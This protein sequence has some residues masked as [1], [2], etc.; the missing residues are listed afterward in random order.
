M[1][2]AILADL[3]VRGS[4]LDVFEAQMSAAIRAM[5]ERDVFTAFVAGDTFDR[6][7]IHDRSASTGRITWTVAR[8]LANSGIRWYLVDGNHDKPNDTTRSAN[9]SLASLDNVTVISEPSRIPM[10]EGIE[11]YCVPWYYEAQMAPRIEEALRLQDEHVRAETRVLIGHGQV[12]GAHMSGT[13]YCEHGHFAIG[14]NELLA[15]GFDHIALGDFHRRQPFYV[16]ALRQL[17]HGEEGNPQGFEIYDTDSN[18]VEWVELREAPQYRTLIWTQG[19]PKPVTNPA[20]VT[21]I[22]TE[23]W[24]PTAAEIGDIG[25]RDK[26]DPV[27][28]RQAIQR[29]ID[30][31]PEGI[32]SDMHAV[33]DLYLKANDIEITKELHDELARLLEMGALSASGLQRSARGGTLDIIETHIKEI[34][35]H[36]DLSIDWSEFGSLVAILA[37]NGT[38]KTILA[39]ADFACLHGEFPSYPGPL[40]DVMTQNGS[41]TSELRTVFK[42]GEDRYVASRRLHQTAKTKSHEAT[43][44][45]MEAGAPRIVAGPKVGDFDKAIEHLLGSKQSAL[46]SWFS[47]QGGT[48]DICL[49]PVVDRRRVFGELMG[50]DGLEELSQRSK[51]E[52]AKETAELGEIERSIEAEAGLP[53]EIRAKDEE[54]IRV[55][56]QLLELGKEQTGADTV[57]KNLTDTLVGRKEILARGEEAHKGA[58]DIPRLRTD[59]QLARLDSDAAAQAAASLPSFEAKASRLEYADGQLSA[60]QKYSSWKTIDDNLTTSIA[61]QEN[62]IALYDITDADRGNA[63]AQPTVKVQLDQLNTEAGQLVEKNAELNAA[64]ASAADQVKAL[65]ESRQLSPL[66]GTDCAPCPILASLKAQVGSTEEWKARGRDA[67]LGLES[68]KKGLARLGPL[69]EAEENRLELCK[70]ASLKIA[71]AAVHLAPARE[72]LK[73]YEDQ[74]QSHRKLPPTPS[75]L[76]ELQAANLTTTAKVLR[77]EVEQ[78]PVLRDR[79]SKKEELEARTTERH[80][81]LAAAEQQ[82]KLLPDL[83]VL[84]S[85]IT[86]A[87]LEATEAVLRKDSIDGQVV[88]AKEHR[89][90]TA[91]ALEALNVRRKTVWEN[92]QRTSAK[93]ARVALLRVLQEAFGKKGAQALLLDASMADLEQ[94]AHEIVSEATDGRFA[95]EIKTQTQNADGSMKEDLAIM[96]IDQH[97]R[98]DVSRFSGGEKRL[99]QIALRIAM[100]R[101]IARLTGRSAGAIRIDETF[102]ALDT[103]RAIVVIEMFE[104]LKDRFSRVILVTHNPSFASRIPDRIELGK[105]TPAPAQAEPEEME[106]EEAPL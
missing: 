35:P 52:A 80:R 87:A 79:A 43:L 38:G 92:T 91:E 47:G 32:L 68:N 49:L 103:E 95:I 31:I 6:D 5:V 44:E 12:R 59:Y 40:Y 96:A 73:G 39:E 25:P 81:V 2:I 42:Y 26:I 71:S 21:R 36:L 28:E 8:L 10:G 99:F 76:T 75:D 41:G 37:A 34:G 62:T 83:Y 106:L 100:T 17:N 30:D 98:R 1:K 70:A 101:W 60:H 69:I 88:E 105:Q 24:T 54:L 4:D 66:F 9:W 16:G 51:Q 22:R 14:S 86:A 94:D 20:E 93:K 78:L 85:A 65:E 18:E 90:R 104:R 23:G 13:Q 29:R 97:G 72:A 7:N 56:G 11:F 55:D 50:S 3:H 58:P 45:I 102:D 77:P 63:A 82:I 15:Y 48:G 74:L 61:T 33:L 89:A 19:E 46:V 57:L 67:E 84:R 27:I 53:E 64:I